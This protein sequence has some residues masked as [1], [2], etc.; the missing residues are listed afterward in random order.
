MDCISIKPKVA[1]ACLRDMVL[2]LI[3]AIKSLSAQRLNK[4]NP[5]SIFINLPQKLGRADFKT[6]KYYCL[7]KRLLLKHMVGFRIESVEVP[8]SK[9]PRHCAG[10]L[11]PKIFFDLLYRSPLFIKF[12]KTT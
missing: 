6:K 10:F 5:P 8:Y 11:V 9:I 12:V 2:E 4:V 1:L 7:I 3:L